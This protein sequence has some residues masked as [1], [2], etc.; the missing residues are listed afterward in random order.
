MRTELLYNPFLLIE[1]L[2]QSF[3]GCRRLAK[4]R[5]SSAAGLA[6]GHLDTLEL[7]E[8][9]KPFEPKVIYDVGANVGHWSL[10]AQ[11]IFPDAEIHAFEP[12]QMHH[13]GFHDNTRHGSRVELHPVA[14]GEQCSVQQMR[15]TDF[16]D[17]SSLLEP[18]DASRRLFN[19]RKVHDESVVVRALDAYSTEVGLPPPDLIKLDIQGYELAALRGAENALRSAKAI[20]LE[21]SFVEF[22]QKQ[23]SFHELVAFLADRSFYLHA[24]GEGTPIGRPLVQTDVLFLASDEWNQS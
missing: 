16:S 9:V 1:R 6:L 4:L 23:C 15:V 12:L 24:L 2:G 18:A 11:A 7:L 17:A 8:L 19:L 13:P 21:V 10:L 5:N 3:R 20:L 14:L 22:Y